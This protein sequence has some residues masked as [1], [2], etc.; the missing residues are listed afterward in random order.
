MVSPAGQHLHTRTLLIPFR[1]PICSLC[2][3]R[4]LRKVI[5]LAGRRRFNENA[6]VTNPERD[7]GRTLTD[8]HSLPSDFHLP[9]NTVMSVSRIAS[10]SLWTTARMAAR[11]RSNTAL[12]V[13][14]GSRCLSSTAPRPAHLRHGPTLITAS[15]RRAHT[16]TMP[17]RP[18]QSM[19]ARPL[20]LKS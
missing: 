8:L 1:P 16:S 18:I 11:S 3:H 17:E 2:R 15:T 4:F 7:R 5:H 9:S 14:A 6:L 20:C 12:A 19:S 13:I 10:P